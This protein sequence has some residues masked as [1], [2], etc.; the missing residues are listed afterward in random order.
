MIIPNAYI[1][2][3]Q[4]EEPAIDPATGYPTAQPQDMRRSRRIECQAVPSGGS[5]H[6]ADASSER[7]QERTFTLY[8]ELQPLPEDHELVEL[9]FLHTGESTRHVMLCEPEIL[10]AVGEIKLSLGCP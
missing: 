5:L 9:T 4:R 1:S 10:E 2:F 8:I 6:K 3:I 7:Y